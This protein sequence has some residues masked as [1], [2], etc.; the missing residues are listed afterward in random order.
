MDVDFHRHQL[1]K[2]HDEY[3]YDKEVAFEEAESE[4]SWD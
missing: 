3:V 1:G 4:C 2:D